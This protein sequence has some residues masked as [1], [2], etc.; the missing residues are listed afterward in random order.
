MYVNSSLQ[1][2]IPVGNG[3]NY[4]K[5]SRRIWS[6][7]EDQLLTELVAQNLSWTEISAKFPGASIDKTRNHWRK[8][9]NGA[10]R[11]PHI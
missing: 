9:L 4:P 1:S 11:N 5:R 10:S 8:T 3:H 2:I 7:D 6:E